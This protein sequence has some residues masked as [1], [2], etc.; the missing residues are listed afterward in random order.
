ML[1]KAPRAGQLDSEFLP[2]PQRADAATAVSI[3]VVLQLILPARLVVSGIPLSLS[4]A[5]MVALFLGMWWFCAQLTTTLGAAKG[6][7]AVRTVLFAYSFSIIATYGYSTFG[8]LP[9][10][11]LNLTDHYLILA[12]GSVGV[13]LAITDGVRDRLRLDFVLKTVVVV[14]AIVAVIGILQYLFDLD[15]T[16][17]LDLPGLRSLGETYIAERAEMRRV[18]ATTAHPIE[19]GVI[20][21]MF[22]PLAVHL[23]TKARHR[24]EPALRWWICAALIAAG[25][26][27]SISRSAILG[28]ACAGVVLFLGWSG[29]R[30][31][32][33]LAVVVGFLGVMKL[34]APGL[35][36]AIYGLFANI[37]SD[38]S[39]QYRT[40]DYTTA[41]SEVARHLWLGRGI[42]TWYAPK[43][44]VFDNQYLLSL[45]ET[46]VFGLVTFIGIF[47]AGMYAGVRARMLSLDP[48]DRELGLTLAAMLTVT[49][50]GCATFDLGG[51]PTAAAMAFVVAGSAGA[52]LRI[53]RADR[54]AVPVGAVRHE[55]LERSAAPTGSS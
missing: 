17:Y 14:G 2:A 35:I 46:G 47:A 37:G 5:S 15:L 12:L 4:P 43:H 42:G 19:F 54:S 44:Q 31:L 53:V 13:A 1:T 9:S 27:F 40:H 38:D 28:I 51:F 18:P 48:M 49:V 23:A 33:A 7:S 55:S 21:A 10:D 30:R 6:R 34:V 8:Y 25:L 11:E 26:M 36:S 16:R 52:L 45:V 3:F 24:L 22:L 41:A 50:V 32:T 39:I 20:S 29:R